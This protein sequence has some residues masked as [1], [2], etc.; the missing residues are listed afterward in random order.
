MMS[1]SDNSQFIGPRPI[2]RIA[3]NGAD[4]ACGRC[5]TSI[6]LNVAVWVLICGG[7]ANNA[8]EKLVWQSGPEP[9]WRFAGQRVENGCRLYV[10]IG[11]AENVL[12]E[13]QGRRIALSNAAETVA[14]SLTMDVVSRYA[15]KETVKGASH[16]GRE[17]PN[18]L[19]RSEVRAMSEQIVRGLEAREWYYEKWSVRESKAREFVRYKYCVLAAY[20]DAEYE[21]TSQRL[22][23]VLNAGDEGL[24]SIE[25]S[26]ENVARAII[27]KVHVRRAEGNEPTITVAPLVDAGTSGV[28]KLGTEAASVLTRHLANLGGGTIKVT[29]PIGLRALSEENEDALRQL[30]EHSINGPQ[31]TA[32]RPGLAGASDYLVVGSTMDSDQVVRLEISA[33]DRAGNVVTALGGSVPKSDE[34]RS[35]M[36]Y[37]RHPKGPQGANGA[38][39]P[40]I[41]V[42][43]TLTGLCGSYMKD[44]T[45][46]DGAVLYSGD[47]FQVRFQ[48]VSDCYVYLIHFGPDGRAMSLFP[49]PKI[50]MTNFCRGGIEY[51]VPEG[52][53]WYTL[54]DNPG[55][56]TVY[57]VA[58]YER[59]VDEE[60]KSLLSRIE[61]AGSAK[62][63]DQVALSL[64][65]GVEELAL[66]S[67]SSAGV[68]IARGISGVE[69][70]VRF[71]I[72]LPDR[73][74]IE[75]VSEVISGHFTAVKRVRIQHN[76]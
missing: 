39:V 53:Q 4:A 56:E 76:R 29:Q 60:L 61:K 38:E 49:H 41:Q 12:D 22:A 75:R 40:P 50:K 31:G 68:V 16:K 44:E 52:D 21:R 74:R 59:V 54:D 46:H 20:P 73:N 19:I 71:Q 33:L 9:A 26:L 62:G 42:H 51:V 32:L 8:T 10:G 69:E 6:L 7:C 17:D 15:Q 2:V 5:L 13:Q 67:R 14:Q 24:A 27:D 43:W 30:S 11:I 36:W 58:S 1:R 3:I 25:D 66:H 37:V 72:P 45:L 35:L 64:S 34:V 48:A 18:T 47:K 70:V 57:L 65:E 55:V 63:R 23:S 28:R